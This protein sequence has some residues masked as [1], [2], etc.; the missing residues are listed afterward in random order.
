MTANT[1]NS[2]RLLAL[3]SASNHVLCDSPRL[4]AVENTL[5][6]NRSQLIRMPLIH[7]AKNY[8]TQETINQLKKVIGISN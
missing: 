7:C 4:S 6:K 5:T 1:E 3:L 8:L 2:S